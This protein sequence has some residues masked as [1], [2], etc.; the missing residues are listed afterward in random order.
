MM[1]HL[2]G[3]DSLEPFRLTAIAFKLPVKRA[4]FKAGTVRVA[5]E[6]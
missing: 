5:H 2:T 4:P 1:L 3:R 6:H